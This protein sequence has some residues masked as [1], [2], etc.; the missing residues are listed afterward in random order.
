MR[1]LT[2]IPLVA[3]AVAA[4]G[5]GIA[6]KKEPPAGESAAPAAPS[7]AAGGG[8]NMVKIVS[9][10]PRTG[11]ANAQSTTIVNGIRL[12]IDEAGGKVGDFTIEYEDWDDA[13]AK[14]GDWDPEVEASNADK[15]ANDKNILFYLGTYNSGAAKISMPVLNKAGLVMISPANTYPGLTKPGTGEANEPAVYRPS[16]KVTYYRVVPADDIQGKVGAEFVKQ[17]GLKSVYVIY[18]GGLYGQG[19][20]NVFVTTAQDVGLKVLSQGAEKIDPKAQEFRSLMTKIKALKPDVVYYG[21]TTQSNAGQ[22]AKDIVAVGLKA[23][24]MVPDGCYEKAFIQAAGAENVNDRTFVTFGGLPPNELKGKGAEFVAAYR[25]RFKGEPEG[26]AVYGYVA[27]KVALEAL[28]KAGKKDRDA[29]RE[30]MVGLG[31]T[32]GALGSWKFDANG[33]TS[34]TTMSVNTIK[35]GQFEFVR[36]MGGGAAK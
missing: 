31:Q 27:A 14:K 9:S 24:L 10:L 21:A 33:D 13:S 5:L 12:A 19:V 15:A 22:I 8:G 30:A 4:A 1:A 29:V 36:L 16:G 26:Y 6:C 2:K 18:D 35:K 17:Q 20:A 28:A 11:S 25:T 34:L 7:P 23:K 32:D 3:V